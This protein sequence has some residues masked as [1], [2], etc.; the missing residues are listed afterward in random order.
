MQSKD[1]WVVVETGKRIEGEILD[2]IQANQAASQGDVLLPVDP[3]IMKRSG[4]AGYY[5]RAYG[6][7]EPLSSASI[8]SKCVAQMTLWLASDTFQP[9]KLVWKARVFPDPVTRKMWTEGRP[10]EG[11]MRLI[12]DNSQESA[13]F[14]GRA[15]EQIF[16]LKNIAR[17]TM[18]DDGI[19]I[20]GETAITIPQNGFYGVSLFGRMP[21]FNLR[22]L[23]ASQVTR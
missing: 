11:F 10:L 7:G 14:F 21:G 8:V 15:S 19:V 13:M 12:S 22:W 3:Q 9:T 23:A 18:P 17:V 16:E 1:N 4:I 5:R 20:G 6:K 2:G